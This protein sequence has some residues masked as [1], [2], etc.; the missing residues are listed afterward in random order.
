MSNVILKGN[1]SGT[2]TV[3]LESPNTNSDRTISLPDSNGTVMV[4]GNMPAFSAYIT[5]GQSLTAGVATKG[6]FD[7]IAW[8][9]NS[10]YSTTNK[11][12]TPNVAGYYQ[13][14]GHIVLGSLSSAAELYLFK[15][16][17]Y[18]KYG[19]TT[20]ANSS[21]PNAVVNALVYCNGTTDYIELYI[22][23]NSNQTTQSGSVAT[24]FDGCLVRSA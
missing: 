17:T 22:A 14:N 21:Y 8:D 24:S 2:G 6:N 16:G 12:F 7:A 1:A 23:C 5:S 13:I 4:S 15:N 11:R 9:T 10:C 3:T 18:H 20:G 19:Q